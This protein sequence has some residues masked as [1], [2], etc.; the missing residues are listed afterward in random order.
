MI[1]LY[2]IL[3]VTKES[4]TDQIRQAFF[5]KAMKW[6]PDKAPQGV[7]D[8][9]TK[10]L[11]EQYE[12]KYLELQ[13]AYKILANPKARE[14]YHQT[15]QAGYD[16]LRRKEERDMGYK[17]QDKYLKQDEKGH[18]VMDND[19]FNK[20]FDQ[21]RAVNDKQAFDQLHQQYNQKSTIHKQDIED[22]KAQREREEEAIREAKSRNMFNQDG[23]FD[24]NQ[25]N[26]TYD[27]IKKTDPNSTGLQDYGSEPRGLFSGEQGITELGAADLSNNG[28]V[29]QGANTADLIQGA[30]D[31]A[32]D[33]DAS[34]FKTV[35]HTQANY[36]SGSNL[37]HQDRNYGQSG[38]IKQSELDARMAAITADRERLMG[39][40]EGEFVVTQTEVEQQFDQLF[41]TNQDAANNRI[42]SRDMVKQRKGE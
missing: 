42:E 14:Q 39:L 6:H 32:R 38:A 35:D 19:Q 13:R 21:T 37:E 23:K 1:D 33:F 10:E 40:K 5:K 8:Y 16:D 36:V 30:D 28:V 22:L 12:K 31:V 41:D 18:L 3:G 34:Q 17:R 11:R 7:S 9:E 2:T 15:Q 26:R 27:H 4:T 24:I 20:D 29:F 25:F